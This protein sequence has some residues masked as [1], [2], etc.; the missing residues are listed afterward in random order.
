MALL[1]G[2]RYTNQTEL[3]SP[4]GGCQYKLAPVPTSGSFFMPSLAFIDNKIIACPSFTPDTNNCW[5]YNIT[6]NKWSGFTSVKYHLGGS[7]ISYNNKIYIY[8]TT[9][10]EI[11]DIKDNTTSSWPVPAK[12]IGTWPGLIL[13][14]DTILAFGGAQAN[15][16]QSFNT[17]SKLWTVLDQG[18]AP[19][20]MFAPTC[21]LL[22]SDEV[23]VV[24]SYYALNGCALYSIKNNSWLKLDNVKYIR[25][26]SSLVNLNGRFF[27]MGGENVDNKAVTDIVEEFIYETKSWVTQTLKPS[28]VM[29]YSSAI[30]LP[31]QLFAYQIGGCKGL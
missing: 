7:G 19:I 24:A 17:S 14:K 21:I 20:N 12:P 1:V 18:L 26:G 27:V 5:S 16:V 13:W 22:P 30:A 23:L 29:G 11:V 4:N 15:G 10:P 9:T 31:A 6:A 3:F 2:G 28:T 25:R 8:D